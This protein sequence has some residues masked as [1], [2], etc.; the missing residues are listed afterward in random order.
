MTI[1]ISPLSPY[2]T[3][4]VCLHGTLLFL[5]TVGLSVSLYFVLLTVS[6]SI[7]KCTGKQSATRC[8]LFLLKLVWMQHNNDIMT[9]QLSKMNVY[10][11][12]REKRLEP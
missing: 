6:F 3:V 1:I 4:P 9:M 8:M 2:V 5:I 11:P 7:C 12:R 10:V